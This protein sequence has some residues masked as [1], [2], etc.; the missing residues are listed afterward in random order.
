MGRGGG[1]MKIRVNVD[2]VMD[3]SNVLEQAETIDIPLVV[4]KPLALAGAAQSF[5][6][7]FQDMLIQVPEMLKAEVVDV[8]EYND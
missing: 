7:M 1:S 5:E 6:T 3:F 4:R 2:F 8:E